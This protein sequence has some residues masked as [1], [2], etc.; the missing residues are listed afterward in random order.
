M[1]NDK[2]N[3][4]EEF[5]K[6]IETH[7]VICAKVRRGYDYGDT[8]IPWIVLMPD[9]SEEEYKEFLQN[10]NFEY[11]GGYGGQEVFGIICCEDDIW[12]DR[13]EYDGS[14]WW[15]K[16]QYPDIFEEFYDL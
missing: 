9:Y 16:H 13:G 10:M 14:E 7:K 8:K 1:S 3:A 11:D 4:K 2:R 5:L 6:T 15:E 12:F